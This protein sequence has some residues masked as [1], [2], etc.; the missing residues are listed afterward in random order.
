VEQCDFSR[1]IST[2]YYFWIV[3]F[4]QSHI[5]GMIGIFVKYIVLSQIFLN[6]F[7]TGFHWLGNDFRNYYNIIPFIKLLLLRQIITAH[8]GAILGIS[9][10]FKQVYILAMV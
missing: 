5:Y 3:S 10:Y 8:S 9:Y 4:Y 2:T 7:V 1:N 6:Y